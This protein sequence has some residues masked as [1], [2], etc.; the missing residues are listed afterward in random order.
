MSSKR[1]SE[2][3][4]EEARRLYVDEEWSLARISR[5]KG[6]PN[7]PKTIRRWL[8]EM[9]VDI[10]SNDPI[11]PRAEIMKKLRKGTPR[12]QIQEEYGC[13]AKYLSQLAT[14]ALES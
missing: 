3:K 13:S 2:T 14:G 4:K 10:R 1:Y 12:R 6:M 9:D 8:V 7:D 11:Y 5:K